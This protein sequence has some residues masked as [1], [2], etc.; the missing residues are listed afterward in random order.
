ME[1]LLS[2]IR[3]HA[4]AKGITPATVARYG[5]GTNKQ[6]FEKWVSGKA[7]CSMETAQKIRDFMS[8]KSPKY[9]APSKEAA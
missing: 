8:G 9:I 6:T 2:E 5:C 4:K 3:A 7:S 1:Q